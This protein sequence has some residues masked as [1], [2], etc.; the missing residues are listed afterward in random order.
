MWVD[1]SAA[2]QGEVA[3][4]FYLCNRSKSQAVL[5]FQLQPLGVGCGDGIRKR[6]RLKPGEAWLMLLGSDEADFSNPP[7][8][9]LYNLGAEIA[10]YECVLIAFEK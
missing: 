9:W 4:A 1:R 2:Q 8:V 3:V 5:E 6:R 7:S 10:S